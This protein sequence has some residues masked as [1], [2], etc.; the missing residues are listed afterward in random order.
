MKILVA[1]AA[2]ILFTAAYVFARREK[3][4][5]SILLIILAGFLLR[6]VA[7]LDFYL[8]PW[9]ERFHAL[10]AKNLIQHPLKPALYGNPILGYDY[11]DWMTNHVWL[12]KPPLALWCIALSLKIFGIHD[13]AVRIPS[14]LFASCSIYL[15]YRIGKLAFGERTGLLA[16]FLHAINGY[17]IDLCSGRTASD[18]VDTAFLFL[19]EVGVLLSLRHAQKRQLPLFLGTGVAAGL[20]VLTRYL[21]GLIIIPVWL[22]FHWRQDSMPQLLRRCMFLLLIAG[23][24]YAPWEIYSQLQFPQES[25]WVRQVNISHLY[26]AVDEHTGSVLFHVLR[27]HRYFG[28][29][30]YIAIALYFWLAIRRKESAFFYGILFWFAVPY[31]FFSFVATKLPGYTMISAPAVFLI[32]SY[33]CWFLRAQK[34]MAAKL[35]VVVLLLFPVIYCV[36]RLKVFSDS[37]AGPKWAE[38]LRSLSRRLDTE[39]AVIFN[40]K[41][42]IETMFYTPFIAYSF[43]PSAQQEELL[44]HEGYAVAILEGDGISVNRGNERA[45]LLDQEIPQM[46]WQRGE[47]YTVSLTLQNTETTAWLST[48]TFGPFYYLVYFPQKENAPCPRAPNDWDALRTPITLDGSLSPGATRRLTVQV[49]APAESGIYNLQW[50]IRQVSR[51]GKVTKMG[52][53]TTS[54]CVTVN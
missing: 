16:A 13:F 34:G 43:V 33:S 45:E 21:P 27:I 47:T 26:Q 51:A 11:Q 35:L 12:F 37:E 4:G 29:F 18:H 38:D 5:T 32:L 53:A 30:A 54:T 23:A 31:L 20:A 14:L 15:T 49:T 40:T 52:P 25:N 41:R 19:I 28:V 6:F 22:V 9:D 7:S 17:L 8:H 39:K 50:R 42:P 1:I 48:P 3:H 46:P 44:I 36:E 2:A 10:V 24:V